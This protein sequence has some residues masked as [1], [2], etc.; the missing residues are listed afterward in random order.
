M[1]T[2]SLRASSIA[3]ASRRVLTGTLKSLAIFHAVSPLFTEYVLKGALSSGTGM[4]RGTDRSGPKDPSPSFRMEEDDETLPPSCACN[5]E[6]GS[7][8]LATTSVEP[9][10]EF[11]L[12][13]GLPIG[14]DPEMAVPLIGIR[15]M[16]PGSRP[17]PPFRSRNSC[18]STPLSRAIR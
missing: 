6:P 16:A 15:T 3:F 8:V 10:C 12:E 18:G 1:F 11:A 13:A 14:G 4:A 5:P 17:L 9:S 2:W 7:F